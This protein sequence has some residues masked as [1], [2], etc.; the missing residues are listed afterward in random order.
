M[1]KLSLI[2]LI[3]TIVIFSIDGVAMHFSSS[4]ENTSQHLVI[5]DSPDLDLERHKR[6]LLN[7]SDVIDV[8]WL[9]TL[10]PLVRNVQGR[11]IWSSL[12]QTGLVSFSGLPKIESFQ[13]YQL[14]VYDLEGS[15]DQPVS[16][17]RFSVNNK[18]MLV[19]NLKT[20]RNI[21]RPYKFEL[22]LEDDKGMYA[23]HLLMAQP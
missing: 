21:K 18:K 1:Q 2:V 11:L 6:Y 4:K 7:Q 5:M 15:Y 23:K 9:R 22:T 10:N 16:L 12:Q 20:K 3:T 19:V 8:N 13:R 17:A 14:W